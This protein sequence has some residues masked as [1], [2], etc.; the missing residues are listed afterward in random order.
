MIVKCPRR[1]ATCICHLVESSS[2][3]QYLSKSDNFFDD[4]LGF[5]RLAG[6]QF[7]R[8]FQRHALHVGEKQA[9]GQTDSQKTLPRAVADYVAKDLAHFES[10]ILNYKGTLSD[11]PKWWLIIST[12]PNR[13]V[14]N[15]PWYDYGVFPQGKRS[16]KVR[17]TNPLAYHEDWY[18]DKL[19]ETTARIRQ[20]FGSQ[21]PTQIIW[22]NLDGNAL[23]TRNVNGQQRSAEGGFSVRLAE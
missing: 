11:L 21:C 13:D 2:L 19:R 7:F 9:C 23:A 8:D 15:W 4:G 20:G 6:D 16:R 1:S 14:K 3:T 17:N 22:A 12:L 10:A 5:Q 18:H